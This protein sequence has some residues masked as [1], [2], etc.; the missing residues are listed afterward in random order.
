MGAL[1]RYRLAWWVVVLRGEQLPANGPLY[2]GDPF[3]GAVN[4][5]NDFLKMH[6]ADLIRLL[7]LM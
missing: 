2:A 3:A 5:I 4:S 7:L 6:Y 1:R